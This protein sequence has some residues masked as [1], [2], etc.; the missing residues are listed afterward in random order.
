MPFRA[1][2]NGKCIHAE[3]TYPILKGE[4]I[5]AVGR[6]LVHAHHAKSKQK[7]PDTKNPE[8]RTP[9]QNLSFETRRALMDLKRALAKEPDF[10][11]VQVTFDHVRS[12]DVPPTVDVIRSN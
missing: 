10:H 3:C 6:G 1:D 11:G 5:N 7:K 9:I 8:M 4:L 2:R 12:P